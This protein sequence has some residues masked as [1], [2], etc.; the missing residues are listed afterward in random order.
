MKCMNRLFPSFLM[1]ALCAVCAMVSSCGGKTENVSTNKDTVVS[2]DTAAN[3]ATVADAAEALSEE[4]TEANQEDEIIERVKEIY[5][6]V[7]KRKSAADYDRLEQRYTT[8]TWRKAIKAVLAKD[9]KSEDE[10]GFFDF[11]YWSMSQDDGDL[12]VKNIKVSNIDVE[13]GVATVSVE[14]HNYGSVTPLQL[15]MRRE[16]DGWRINNFGTLLQEMEEYVRE[17]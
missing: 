14:L 13:K 6:A 2:V 12:K 9:A 8:R 17:N 5:A 1:L 4:D 15:S 10:V 16:D 11:D 3:R 7:K